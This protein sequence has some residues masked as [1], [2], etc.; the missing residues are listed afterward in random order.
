M[1]GYILVDSSASMKYGSTGISKFQ[2]AC[3]LASSLAYLMLIQQDE[4]GVATFSNEILKLI[5]ARGGLEHIKAITGALE[6]SECSGKVDIQKIFKEL[7][8]LIKKEVLLFLFLIFLTMKKKYFILL[9]HSGL[10]K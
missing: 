7:S 8:V 1:K 3:Y 5:P 9:R 6:T 2:Y 10:E 4:V